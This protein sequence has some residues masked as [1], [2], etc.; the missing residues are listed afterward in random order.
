MDTSMNRRSFLSLAGATGAALA[1]GSILASCSPA[2]SSSKAGSSQPDDATAGATDA[3]S[4]ATLGNNKAKDSYDIEETK[5]ADLVVVGGGTAGAAAACRGRELGLN[6]TLVE[7][8]NN[9]GGTSVMTEGLFAVDSHW[10]KE[11]GKNPA[12][13]GYDLFSKAMDYHH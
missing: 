9:T 5:Q 7:V 10:Q 8:A 4:K 13:L 3:K 11:N 2:G 12:D 1:G 6:V